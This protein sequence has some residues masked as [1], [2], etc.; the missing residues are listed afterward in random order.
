MNGRTQEMT[1]GEGTYNGRIPWSFIGGAVGSALREADS[2]AS[3][4]EPMLIVYRRVT[5]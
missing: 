1:Q 5:T 3:I 4:R 2:T